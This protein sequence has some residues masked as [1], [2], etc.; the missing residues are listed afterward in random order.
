M[1]F[2]KLFKYHLYAMGIIFVVMATG[3]FFVVRLITGALDNEGNG[4]G[5][6]HRKAGAQKLLKEA[7][8]EWSAISCPKWEKTCSVVAKDFSI[9]SLECS[10][11]NDECIFSQV[12][13]V[14]FHSN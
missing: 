11:Y 4:T 6:M 14:Q 9:Y 10:S 13:N 3:L 7:N 5:Q 2:N 1:N 8:I 12:K